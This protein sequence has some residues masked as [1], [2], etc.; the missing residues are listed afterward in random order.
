MAKHKEIE[1][2][3]QKRLD[4]E[5]C[6]E[7]ERILNLHLAECADC[8][9]IYQELS[10]IEQELAGLI[11][12]FPGYDFND[13]LLRKLDVK[14]SSVWAKAAMVLAG[15]WLASFLF[16]AFSPLSKNILNRILFSMPDFMRVFDKTKMILLTITQVLTPLAKNFV[17]PLAPLAGLILIVAMFYLFS[18]T[19]KKEAKCRAL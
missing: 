7:E 13:R 2:L 15:V 1:R 14:K 16:L 17:N 19:V 10:Q 5:T 3:I 8:Q 11:E 18:K 6:A 12:F 9:R 4:R